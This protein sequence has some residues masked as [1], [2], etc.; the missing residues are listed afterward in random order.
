MLA[1]KI[2][3]GEDLRGIRHKIGVFLIPGVYRKCFNLKN[4]INN[5]K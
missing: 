5:Q 3:K 1:K 4:R 2:L